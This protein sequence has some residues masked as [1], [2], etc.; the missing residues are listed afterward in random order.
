M[1]RP[2]VHVMPRRAENARGPDGRLLPA[3]QTLL[4]PLRMSEKARKA[5]GMAAFEARYDALMEQVCAW[6]CAC[7]GVFVGRLS[8]RTCV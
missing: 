8:V 4:N 6:E 5:T 7:G 1:P 2:H 3:P